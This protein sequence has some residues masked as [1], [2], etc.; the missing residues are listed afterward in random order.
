M[1]QDPEIY[2]YNSSNNSYNVYEGLVDGTT[3]T[4]TSSTTTSSS[5]NEGNNIV[6]VSR[7]EPSN[8]S[9]TTSTKDEVTEKISKIMWW[10]A[11]IIG[12]IVGAGMLFGGIYYIWR[13]KDKR[14]G[15]ESDTFSI[16]DSFGGTI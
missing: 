6:N 4:S 7:N 1:F 3:T 10:L 8:N 16:L 12:G 15:A 5:T 13:H 14:G 9:G 2:F 11:F